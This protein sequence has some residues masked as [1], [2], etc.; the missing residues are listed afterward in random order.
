MLDVTSFYSADPSL[1]STYGPQPYIQSMSLEYN[2][3]V[4]AYAV[5]CMCCRRCMGC[6]VHVLQE[7]H[8]CMIL[9]GQGTLQKLL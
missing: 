7:V 5:V 1:V 2:V 4:E 6:C 3:G 9:E 8:E